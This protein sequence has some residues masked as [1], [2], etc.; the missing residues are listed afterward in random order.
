MK[1]M[2][3][4][5]S[6]M[7]AGHLARTL[8]LAEAVQAVGGRALVVS[9]GREIGH[10]SAA[11]PVEAL[12]PVWSD[13]VDYSRLLTPEGEAD[14]A[15]M[16]ARAARLL[17]LFDEFAPE[18]L[19]TELFPFGR[20][21]LRHEFR[22]LLA[23]AAGRA[24]IW[25]SVRDVLEPKRKKG[26]EEETAETLRSFYHGVLVHGDERLIPLAR[27]WPKAAEMGGMIRHTG[28][29]AAPPPPPLETGP[30]EA[31]RG[32]VLVS[33]GGGAIGRGLLEAAALA[34]RGSPRRWRLRVGGA[35]AAEAA[36]RLRALAPGAPLVAEPAAADHR[37]RLAAAACSVSL[38]GYNTATDLLAAGTPAVISPM[39]E[40][41]EREQLIRAEAF[42]RLP[43]FR[44][45]DEE[46]PEALACAV[47]AAIAAGGPPPGLARLDGAARAA[48]I[49][50]EAEG[51]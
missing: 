51:I 15:W 36:A 37:A 11:I 43:G 40:G 41:G 50:L 19:V 48:E 18:A 6:L 22:A 35:D 25:A 39:R 27:T 21:A 49:I 33:V 16:E 47:E 8:L 4:V 28:Y 10:L 2:F 31:A 30:L 24:R 29:V 7:G 42:A 20:R 9:G 34:S 38:L 14:E 32:E 23:R 12:P 44:V 45:L 46:T 5:T 1:V 3:V 17:A 13:G 26:R